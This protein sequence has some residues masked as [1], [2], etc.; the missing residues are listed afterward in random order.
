MIKFIYTALRLKAS[1]RTLLISLYGHRSFVNSV[2]F[3]SE[4]EEN[5]YIIACSL[6]CCL[7]STKVQ[8]HWFGKEK[9]E[10]Q[11]EII[12]EIRNS[13]KIDNATE[14][15]DIIHSFSILDS[16]II[17]FYFQGDAYSY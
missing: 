16:H 4:S 12:H 1:S 6:D 10:K 13:Y 7:S 14:F 8:T 3:F 15:E 2:R 11:V 17:L 5:L 9:K